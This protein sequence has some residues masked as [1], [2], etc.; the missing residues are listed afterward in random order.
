MRRRSTTVTARLA[1]GAATTLVLLLAQQ[2]RLPSQNQPPTFRGGASYVR[3][4]MYPSDSKGIVSDLQQSDVE[5]LEDGVPQKIEQFEL[6]TI[7]PG[8][9]EAT[10]IEP[11]SIRAGQQ[12]AADPRA[13]VFVIFFDTLHVDVQTPDRIRTPMRR[14]MEEALGPDDLVAIMAPKMA[15][16]SLT[17]TRRTTVLAS[18][19]DQIGFASWK[20]QPYDDLDAT[21]DL[22]QHCYPD[23]R[24]VTAGAMIERRREKLTL[25]A[26]EDLV[27]HLGE[28]REERKTVF[29]V[30]Q[31]W[32]LFT[33][34]TTLTNRHEPMATQAPIGDR[35]RGGRGSNGTDNTSGSSV[36]DQCGHDLMELA[37][38]DDATRLRQINEM[39][40]RRNV[41]FYPIAPGLSAAPSTPLANQPR[42]TT[43]QNISESQRQSELRGMAEDTDGVA[44]VNINDIAEP[45]RRIIA[46]TSSYY[47]LG[48]QSTNSALDGKYRKITVRV[49]RPGIQVR[50]RHGYRALSA[51]EMRT[52]ASTA[53]PL[54]RATDDVARA[55]ARLNSASSRAPVMM[56]TAGWMN[57]E[58]GALWIVGELG[59]ELRSAPA[60]RSGA[61]TRVL[62]TA[63][64]GTTVG[65]LTAELTGTPPVFMVRVPEGTPL[66]AGPYSVRMTLSNAATSDTISDSS[67]ATLPAAAASL[68]EPLLYRRGLA[69]SAQPALTADLQFRRSE[70]LHVELP[71]ASS[72]ETAA[73]VLDSQGKPLAIPVTTTTRRDAGGGFDWVVADVA[74]SPFAASDY[75]MEVTQGD[76]KQVVAF[77][78]IN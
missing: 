33:P 55:L 4:D 18:L 48:Y 17:F 3:V 56:R 29:V 78:V 39:A 37:H 66:K 7:P 16:S 27:V 74:L 38:L 5:L 64:D 71:T 58:K 11:N 43:R 28:I 1:I 65:P 13:R 40:N 68:G 41:S 77:K 20:V 54:L 73:R 15:T 35:L 59:T 47:L 75:V 61:R 69:A 19:L 50:A 25:D 63:S 10:R 62:L 9:P 23:P 22:Y 70:R 31:G 2:Q 21:E 12:A 45:M 57:G 52:A 44:I 67:S 51:A 60:W 34:D 36:Q 76:A 72:A 30:T 14:F 53:P 26:L 24:D 32:K 8:G 49:K 6:V 46:D 42:I